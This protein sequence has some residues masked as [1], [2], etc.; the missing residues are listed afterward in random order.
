MKT[1]SGS[2]AL[3]AMVFALPALCA[4]PSQLQRDLPILERDLPSKDLYNL[5]VDNSTTV[6]FKTRNFNTIAAIYAFGGY[7][8]SKAFIKDGFKAVPKGLFNANASG[9]ISPVGNFSGAELSTEYFF[10]LSPQAEAPFYIAWTSWEIQ[11]FQSECANVAV[12]KVH[13]RTTIVNPGAPNDG[14]F[15]TT[16][17]QTAFW[18]FDDEGA[19]IAYDAVIPNLGSWFALSYRVD[20]TDQ[21]V[22]V[23]AIE[24]LCTD[25]EKNC[26]GVN[27]Q[28]KE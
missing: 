6:D 28:Y 7:P 20:F 17:Q 3:A 23:Q 13:G 5:T 10:G 21:A 18:R 15:L 22:R 1:F 26:E 9:R 2:V 24:M 16:L 25:V 4:S 27:K 14:E 11:S 12:S 19:V 8:E